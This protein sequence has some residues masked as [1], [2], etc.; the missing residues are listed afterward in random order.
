[1][2]LVPDTHIHVE[3]FRALSK[4][5]QSVSARIARVCGVFELLHSATGPA[6]PTITTLY[7][8]FGLVRASKPTQ[9]LE[10]TDLPSSCSSV[11]ESLSRHLNSQL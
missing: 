5:Y 10:R 9:G 8:A 4:L 6:E 3:P 1:M 2:P 7:S 11:R